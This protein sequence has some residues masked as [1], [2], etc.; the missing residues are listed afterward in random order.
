MFARHVCGGFSSGA[1]KAK[2]AADE[3]G[4]C[5]LCGALDDK[6]HR[7]LHCPA[8]EHVRT[9]SREH[10]ETAL[11]LYPHWVHGPYGVEP[12]DAEVPR[13]IFATR[14]LPSLPLLPAADALYL[15]SGGHLTLFTDGSC[16]NPSIPSASI[17]AFAV[18]QDMSRSP[19][20]IPALRSTWQ[21]TGIVPPLLH[22]VT[23][24]SVP[25]EQSINRAEFCAVIQ[26]CRHAVRLGA[27]ATTIWT[28]SA[29][30]IAEWERGR[31]Q[32]FHYR[33]LGYLLTTSWRSQFDLRKVKAHEDLE[34]LDGLEW[35]RAAGN[36][37]AD[38]AAKAAVSSDY[39]FFLDIVDNIAEQERLQRDLLLLFTRFLVALS[40]EESILKKAVRRQDAAVQVEP[41]ADPTGR[42]ADVQFRAWIQLQPLPPWKPR[43]PK[44][45]RDWLLATSWPPWFSQAIWG[46]A[47]SLQ[48]PVTAT[49]QGVG[50]GITYL[51]LLANFVT[52]LLP[53]SGLGDVDVS[54]AQ[55]VA[56]RPRSLRQLIQCFMDAIR[57][58][59]RLSGQRLLP[60]RQGKVYGLRALGQPQPRIGVAIR[61]FLSEPSD[62]CVLLTAVLEAGGITPLQ[63]YAREYPGAL[64]FSPAQDTID[65]HLATTVQERLRL[66][67]WLR[68]LRGTL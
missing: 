60:V 54:T 52:K 58:L 27:P 10:V 57:Q 12:P 8:T 53:P 11:A 28:D 29:F 40:K 68:G 33:D 50:R 36:L 18:V 41:P 65:A 16:R 22:V 35:W 49:V 9:L 21:I 32:E 19:S 26:A 2:W 46:W 55:G 17:A 38:L 5:P 39:G 45:Q 59:E 43:L 61:P 6:R 25:G 63:R 31:S 47:M 13:L 64:P 23:Q 67:R 7:L 34:N 66:A 62:T 15:P 48:W 42:P 3:D 14:R 24:G 37:Q 4:T 30:V 51:E 44:W 1:A 56:D 20:Q